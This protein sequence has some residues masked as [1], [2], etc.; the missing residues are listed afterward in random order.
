M[1]LNRSKANVS[2]ADKLNRKRLT[3]QW[4]DRLNEPKK[5][6]PREELDKMYDPYKISKAALNAKCSS[7]IVE[8]SKP[9]RRIDSAYKVNA[10]KV[11]R[12]A[13]TYKATKRI[14][15]LALSR[16]TD[17]KYTRRSVV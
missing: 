7:R 14:E 16:K 8:L 11:K 2:D 5:Y 15:E 13:L 10:F 12:S 6:F 17:V 1:L 9:K 4:V 3:F